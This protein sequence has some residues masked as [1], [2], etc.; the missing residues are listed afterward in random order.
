VEES[1]KKETKEEKKKR[2][3][4]ERAK[5]KAWAEERKK[6][7]AGA[8]AVSSP[9]PK[10]IE[11]ESA[12]DPVKSPAVTKK[13]ST[14]RSSTGPSSAPTPV[15][16]KKV[17]RKKEDS[18]PK[19]QK[20]EDESDDSSTEVKKPSIKRRKTVESPKQEETPVVA[21]ERTTVTTASVSLDSVTSPRPSH[22]K[23]S[24]RS[25]KKSV[26]A[27]VVIA[28]ID[29]NIIMSPNKKRVTSPK[30]KKKV[31]IQE[32]PIVAHLEEQ[33]EE[34]EEKESPQNKLGKTLLLPILITLIGFLVLAFNTSSNV[35]QTSSTHQ[36]HQDETPKTSCFIN[37]GIQ[38][39]TDLKT[40]EKVV[41][42]GSTQKVESEVTI[43]LKPVTCENP[44]PCPQNARC[45]GGMVV[46]CLDDSSLVWKNEDGSESSFYIWNEDT[47][48]CV[49]SPDSLKGILSIHSTLVNL[50]LEQ[51]CS[52]R[53]GL[54]PT[55][56]LS[57]QD[58]WKNSDETEIMFDINAVA[59]LSKVSS[60]DNFVKSM[61][62]L[63]S[64]DTLN[65]PSAV[66]SHTGN[67]DKK[68]VGLSTDFVQNHLPIPFS[69]WLRTLGWNLMSAFASFIYVVI[70]VLLNIGWA[71]FSSNPIP[72][73]IVS[74][75]IY[76]LVW[77]RGR[78]LK[79]VNLRKR[80]VEVQKMAYDKLMIDCN[81]GEGYATLHLRDE[82]AHELYP[83]PCHERK[84]LLN[85]VW[86]RVVNAVRVD[87]R[88]TKSRKSIGGKNLEWWEWVVEPARRSRRSLEG[89]S[90]KKKEA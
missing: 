55:C 10:K 31:V 46:D 7:L 50:T 15:S 18:P 64:D 24:T 22:V 36:L 90:A 19:S 74:V 40:V 17:K 86:P 78:R 67:N 1:P 33:A 61:N 88:V 60:M 11:S 20:K 53:F 89:T 85:D 73:F 47:D 21:V 37:H 4:E 57:S 39:K 80:V 68:Y 84:L 70:G 29:A 56:S 58:V 5:A 83:E 8:A 41:E 44:V 63:M 59:K 32:T 3:A 48:A 82:I 75:L 54:G 6:K 26:S 42:D 87:N 25:T 65:V 34:E 45:E 28:P 52:S 71:I 27:P 12:I 77:I 76:V 69:C 16:S 13:R 81:E 30:K 66:I 9:S 38:P 72:T 62:L 2:L 14:R 49:L 79:N 23:K 43:P 35:T 51:I